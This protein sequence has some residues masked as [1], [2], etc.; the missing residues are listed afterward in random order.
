MKRLLLLGLVSLMLTGCSSMGDAF[1]GMDVF[2]IKNKP[3]DRERPTDEEW[4]QHRN[5]PPVELIP[6]RVNG[7]II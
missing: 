3:L 2:S 6:E 5:Q 7:G 4:G 1:P